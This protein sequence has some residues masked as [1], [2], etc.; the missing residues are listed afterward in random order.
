MRR[1]VRGAR[2]VAAIA[3]RARLGTLDGHER[4]LLGRPLKD[5]AG[6]AS[7]RRAARPA[8]RRDVE[9]WL[10][11]RDDIIAIEHHLAD[12]LADT[13]GQILTTLPGVAVVRAAAPTLPIER[14]PSADHLYSATG[15]APASYQSGSVTRRGRISRQGLAEHRDAL[16]GIAWGSPNT[17]PP[18]VSA[19]ANTAPAGAVR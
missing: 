17:A 7:R 18:L 12:L 4:A 11:L 2:A 16:M 14:W 15:L 10:G 1:R 13:D 9:R 5:A 8:A 6:A 3:R 19:T